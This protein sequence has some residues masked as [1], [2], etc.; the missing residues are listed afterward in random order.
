MKIL[1]IIGSLEVGGAEKQ[2]LMLSK[3]LKGFDVRQAVFVIGRSGKLEK[4]LKNDRVRIYVNKRKTRFLVKFFSVFFRLAFALM[5][6]KPDLVCFI[7]PASYWVGLPISKLYSLITNNRLKTVMLRRSL[8]NYQ[9]MFPFV[10]I[11]E[12][13][14]HKFVDLIIVNSAA[15]K[16]DVTKELAD[17]DRVKLV[18]NGVDQV[19][20]SIFTEAS[21]PL[22]K[23]EGAL[24]LIIVANLL[25]YKGHAFLLESLKIIQPYNESDIHLLIVGF[26]RGEGVNL[27]RLVSEYGLASNVT[28]VTDVTR[29][30]SFYAHSDVAICASS[31]E[32][33][34]NTVLEAMAAGLPVIATKVGGNAEAVVHGQTGLLVDYG[35]TSDMAGAI[36]LLADDPNL[37]KKMGSA[38][39]KYVAKRFSTSKMGQS[40]YNL[41]RQLVAKLD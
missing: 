8:S 12:K 22:A 36:R 2:L 39:K 11:Y 40:Y 41:F 13:Q 4:F 30:A 14:L 35:D 19:N 9:S 21:A 5:K 16:E 26:D 7:L 28:F 17:A 25:R 10:T 32:G 29:L 33:F 38:G 27:R 6:E 18:Y 34:S 31:Q 3:E 20:L 24:N 1:Y 15:V 23:P 37:R